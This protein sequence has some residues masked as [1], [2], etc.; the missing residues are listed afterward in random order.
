MFMN[1]GSKIGGMIAGFAMR[2]M[3]K[4]NKSVQRSS[5]HGLGD[6]IEIKDAYD[7][8]LNSGM[9]LGVDMRVTKSFQSDMEKFSTKS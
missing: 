6:P 5:A 3:F 4:F 2:M 8:L 9:E 1:T 7:R